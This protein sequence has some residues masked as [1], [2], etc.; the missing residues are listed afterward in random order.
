MRRLALALLL[1]ALAAPPAHAQLGRLIERAREA[2]ERPAERAPEPPD[3]PATPAL[4]DGP[5]EAAPEPPRDCPPGQPLP[6]A[7]MARLLGEVWLY[8]L[9]GQIAVQRAQFVLF[10][11]AS[12]DV[13]GRIALRDASGALREEWPITDSHP[14]AKMQVLE[15]LEVTGRAQMDP[16]EPGEYALVVEVDGHLAGRLPLTVRAVESGDPFNPA[17]ISA[18]DG[19]WRTLGYFSVRADETGGVSDRPAEFTFWIDPHDA[20]GGDAQ[21]RVELVQR[22]DVVGCV[23]MGAGDGPQAYPGRFVK[24][25]AQFRKR[26]GCDDDTPNLPS[27]GA[28]G[29]EPGTV[30]RVVAEADGRVIQTYP[31]RVDEAGRLAAHPRSALDYEPRADFLTPRTMT[32]SG[33]TLSFVD[34]VFWVE[35][36]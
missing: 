10:P 8:P 16:L 7:D 31:V 27:W 32:G 21:V 4:P 20:G 26:A 1:C 29:W 19:P 33:G 23:G 11:C 18:F 2:V 17:T 22:G 30:V 25:T 14:M 12:G 5:S 6:G 3:P 13:Q 15:Y 24:R 35:A 28:D 9:V 34:H 36:E